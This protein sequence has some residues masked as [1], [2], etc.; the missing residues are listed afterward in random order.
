M[1]RKKSKPTSA[2]TAAKRKQLADTQAKFKKL[3]SRLAALDKE[4]AVVQA[5]TGQP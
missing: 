3:E 4:Y 2:P 5:A 1:P